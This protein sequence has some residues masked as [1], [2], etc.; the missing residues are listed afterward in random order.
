MV[1]DILPAREAGRQH[2]PLAAGLVE[3][4]DRIDD[5]ALGVDGE[6]SA[7]VGPGCESFNPAPLFVAQICGIHGYGHYSDRQIIK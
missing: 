7:R 2:P 3:V 1:V 4:Q 6:G 5:L